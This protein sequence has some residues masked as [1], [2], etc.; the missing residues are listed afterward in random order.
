[1]KI[2]NLF[3]KIAYSPILAHLIII[4]RCNLTCSYCNEYDDK[5]D[6]VPQEILETRLHKLKELGSLAVCL[7]GG[8]PTLHPALP[9]LIQK[10]RKMGFLR[11][12]VISNGL[13]LHRRYIE[14]L[15]AAG[16]HELQVSVDG[17]TQNEATKKVLNNLKKPLNALREHARFDVTVSAVIGACPIDE[18]HAIVSYTKALGFTPRVLLMH[19]ETGQVAIQ[20]HEV[21]AYEDLMHAIPKTVRDITSGYRIGLLRQGRA[22]FKCRAGSRYLYID[23]EGMMS[24]CSQT[25]RDWSKPLLL[26]GMDDLKA[27]FYTV[28]SCQDKCTLGCARSCSQFDSWRSQRVG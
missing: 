22:P 11:V 9:A 6:P 23:E 26:C 1:M 20:A 3:R 21:Q 8:E 15:N 13:Q 7:T 5:S 12:G 27:Q 4:R 2:S 10:S 14:E 17:A 28:K 19:D 18:I 25:R 16:L 24:W